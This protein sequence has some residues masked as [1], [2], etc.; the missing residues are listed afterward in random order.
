MNILFIYTN[1]IDPNS[2]GVQKMTYTL[3]QY[4]K[5]YSHNIFYL[6]TLKPS[7]A[8]NS[9]TLPDLACPNSA[10]NILFLNSLVNKLQIHLVINQSGINSK[11]TDL[12]ISAK[13]SHTFKLFTCI[14]NSIFGGVDNFEFTH[15]EKLEKYHLSFLTPILSSTI[16]KWVIRELFILKYKKHYSSVYCY[17]DKIILLSNAMKNDFLSILKKN[18]SK[19]ITIIPNFIE[20]PKVI[21]TDS[22]KVNEVIYVGRIDR[23]YKRT[24]LVLKI[25]KLLEVTDWH[26]RIIGDGKSLGYLKSL[27]KDLNLKN[28]TFEGKQNPI[29]YY[30][31]AK[32]LMMTSCSESFGLVLVEG[33]SYGVVPIAFDSFESVRDLIKDDKNGYLIEPY[34]LES[35]AIKIKILFENVDKLKSMSSEACKFSKNFEPKNIVKLWLD[36]IK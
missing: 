17:S 5:E 2:G 24:D 35:Y 20:Y 3:G 4:L 19:K 36:I 7:I 27:S 12:I 28:I 30:E 34:N 1:P 25:W 21:D 8:E 26:L 32:I 16:I 31:K 13:K 11:V 18:S 9:Y 22:T 10:E 15:L 23:T 33:M 6:S 29:P 14:H